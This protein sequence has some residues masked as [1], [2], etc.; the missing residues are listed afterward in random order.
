MAEP[1]RRGYEAPTDTGEATDRAGSVEVRATT[2][3]G[4]LIGSKL[5]RERTKI[6]PEI[7]TASLV[8]GEPTN[9]D[10]SPDARET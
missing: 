3:V 5:L 7:V 9:R 2:G 4:R 6:F 1:A 10:P 8:L